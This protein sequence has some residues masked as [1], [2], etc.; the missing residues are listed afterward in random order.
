MLTPYL[1]QLRKLRLAFSNMF[2]VHVSER[3]VTALEA[4]GEVLE[5]IGADS[6]YIGRTDL[7]STLRASTVDNF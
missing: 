3:Y 4:T 7:L 1:G 2:T 5:G 6:P